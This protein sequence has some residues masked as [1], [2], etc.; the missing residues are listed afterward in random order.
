MSSKGFVFGSFAI[1]RGLEAWPSEAWLK[2]WLEAW[3]V[4][5]WLFTKLVRLQFW[6]Y[7][8]KLWVDQPTHYAT[9]GVPF[10]ADFL[11]LFLVIDLT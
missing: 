3:Q 8:I 2:A 6:F 10:Y 9:Q 4:E 7:L 5:A 11:T 1:I